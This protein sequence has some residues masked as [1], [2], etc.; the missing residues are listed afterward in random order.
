MT[1]QQVNIRVSDATRAKLDALTKRYG[2][3]AEVVAVAIDR[4]YRT[5][6]ESEN[7]VEEQKKGETDVKTK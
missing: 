4:L 3:Q 1:K 6:I 2:T 5:E 7:Y